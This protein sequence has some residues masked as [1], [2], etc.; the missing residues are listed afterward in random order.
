MGSTLVHQSQILE[1]LGILHNSMFSSTVHILFKVH[2]QFSIPALPMRH[3]PGNLVHNQSPF[4]KSLFF[5]TAKVKAEID[6][7][8]FKMSQGLRRIYVFA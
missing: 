6:N 7:P 4:F 1:Q 8:I 3:D 2:S 5:E